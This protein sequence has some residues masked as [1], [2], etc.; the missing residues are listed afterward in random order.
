MYQPRAHGSGPGASSRAGGPDLA[1]GKRTLTEQLPAVAGA[2]GAAGVQRAAAHGVSGPS[3]PLPYAHQI[4][5]LFGRHDVSSVQAH[6]GGAAAEGAAQMGAQA[7]ATGNSIAFRG[8]PDLHTAAHEAAHVVQQRGGVQLKGGVGQVGDAYEQ[9]ADAVADRVVQGRSAESLLDR[10]S[11]GGSAAAPSGAVQRSVTGYNDPQTLYNDVKAQ[12]GPPDDRDEDAEL[13][14]ARGRIT[15]PDF[16][17]PDT[18]EDVVN[19][20]KQ[21][22]TDR[23]EQRK[24]ATRRA[25]RKPSEGELYGMYADEIARTGTQVPLE[26]ALSAQ[27]SDHGV[28]LATR[29]S[30]CQSMEQ[31][32]LF[33]PAKHSIALPDLERLGLFDKQ[34]NNKLDTETNC[35]LIAEHELV[36][37]QHTWHNAGSASTKVAAF[38]HEELGR[39]VMQLQHLVPQDGNPEISNHLHRRLQYIRDRFSSTKM[40]NEAPAV[41]R[42]LRRYLEALGGRRPDSYQKLFDAIVE[43]D[44]KCTRSVNRMP[45]EEDSVDEDSVDQAPV[46]QPL[47]KQDQ[48]TD[49]PNC[50]PLF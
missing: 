40:N 42:E 21:S 10:Y 22:R 13:R 8:A 45:G 1:P 11:G 30:E 24:E 12:I 49:D 23:D 2:G 25:K 7:Y 29:E 9:H 31:G 33:D 28:F 19:E 34:Y 35:R 41:L 20:V 5:A 47:I 50:C 46:D 37:L 6:V 48:R 4:Q 14:I 15:S 16:G 38:S 26:I 44:E 43:Y 32:I 39:T 17:P 36:H 27:G 3:Q 18:L